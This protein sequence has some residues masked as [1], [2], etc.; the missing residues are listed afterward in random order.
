MPKVVP[1]PT[2]RVQQTAAY[3]LQLSASSASRKPVPWTNRPDPPETLGNMLQTLARLQPATVLVLESMVAEIL[4]QLQ[5][6]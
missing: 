2:R 4:Q 6:P 3:V 1:F 5:A